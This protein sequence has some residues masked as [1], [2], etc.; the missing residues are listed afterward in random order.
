LA[1]D[2]RFGLGVSVWSRLEAPRDGLGHARCQLRNTRGGIV[3]ESS[4]TA[5]KSW[6][7]GYR[8]HFVLSVIVMERSPM[9]LEHIRR[10][11]NL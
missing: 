3:C 11:T 7:D 1:V 6:P 2:E 8:R 5:C 4:D 10:G 9:F